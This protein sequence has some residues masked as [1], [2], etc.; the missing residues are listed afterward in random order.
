MKTDSNSFVK[1]LQSC[2]CCRLATVIIFLVLFPLAP[3]AAGDSLVAGGNFL[4]Q[5][6]AYASSITKSETYLGYEIGNRLLTH[7]ELIGYLRLLAAESDRIQLVE[8][9]KT[10]GGRP[11]ITLIIS[12]PENLAN[13]ESLREQHLQLADPRRS[14]NLNLEEL[15]LV[16]GMYY[17]IHGNEPSGANAA[18]LIA[19]HLAAGTGPEFEEFLDK[20]VILLDPCLNPDGLDRFANWSRNN[21]GKN[22]NPDPNTREHVEDWPGGRGNY[23]FFDLNRD[24]MLLTQPESVARLQ[25]YHHW[26]PNLLFDFHEMGTAST[27]FFQ[28]G[29]PERTHPLITPENVALTER[30]SHYFAQALDEAGSL[31]FSKERFDDFYM[32]KASTISD[33]KGAVGFLFEQASSRGLLQKSK[34]GDISFAF[35]VQNQVTISLAVLEAAREQRADLLAYMR[36]FFEDSLEEG[37]NADG[38]GFTFSSP[39]D[40]DRAQLFAEVLQGHDIEVSR[41]GD[42]NLW[43]I[44]AEQPQYRYL[45]ALIEQ[46]TEFDENI[47]Y[48]ITAWT[49]PLAYNLEWEQVGKA[50]KLADPPPPRTLPESDLGYL[51]DWA[52]LNAPRLLFD[53]LEEDVQV[54]VA[55]EPFTMAAEKFGY[56]TLFVSLAGQFEKAAQ[57]HEILSASMEDHATRV[58]AVWTFLTEEGIDLG[59]NQL[60]TVKK[61]KILLASGG[62]FSSTQ[63]GEVWH[64][65]DV[66]HD[67]P[68][69]LVKARQLDKLNL[70]EY[71]VLVVPGADTVE[72]SAELCDKLKG[73][74]ARGGS[75]VFLGKSAKWSIENQLVELSLLGVTE[76]PERTVSTEPTDPTDLAAASVAATP[77]PVPAPER[78]PF[79]AA[80]DDKAL[81][82]IRGAIFDTV[83][84]LSH[85]IAYGLNAMSLPV[86]V[87]ED[88][89][90]A[91]SSSP[92]QTPLVFAEQPLLA[93]YASGENLSLMAG[94]AAVVVEPQGR[95]AVVLF[96]MKPVFRSYWRGTEKLLLNAILFGPLMKDAFE[97]G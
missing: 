97:D 72:F 93:G 45:Q 67:Y 29:V 74:V 76:P 63:T 10:H 33:L 69:T 34:T 58:R 30:I 41:T 60:V 54:M 91:P 51:I 50:P 6:M 65:L 3:D 37:R 26:L 38:A 25:L 95:G 81:T 83:V 19:Y 55:K 86:F 24:W 56:G 49:L 16:V 62:V 52:S 43:F 61:P 14:G 64:L 73:W 22:P 78:R 1:S 2:L 12:S 89:I 75:L 87:D 85:P 28:P 20:T 47:F 90:L 92:Y 13:L 70:D 4:P 42:G 8:T 27:Y 44:P 31:Y 96:G 80:S 11:L 18:L 36:D 84:D 66:L 94:A 46:Q 77:I 79:E 9:G 7:G 48:D 82:R 35:T 88:F 17:S 23:Y 39:G 15:P 40:P 32:G 53:L 68:V 5:E 57:I 21:V 71:T 59:S